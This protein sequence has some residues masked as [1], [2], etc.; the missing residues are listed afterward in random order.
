MQNNS[1]CSMHKKREIPL[2]NL[3]FLPIYW[4]LHS[5]YLFTDLL[6]DQKSILCNYMYN[7]AFVVVSFQPPQYPWLSRLYPVAGRVCP[8][9]LH[10]NCQCSE[11]HFYRS[12]VSHSNTSYSTFVFIV[13]LKTLT[14]LLFSLFSWKFYSQF[15]TYILRLWW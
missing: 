7:N 11:Y 3:I 14:L 12:Q 2:D 8:R 10:Q 13:F 6:L 5:H 4:R 1:I 9:P 15:Y